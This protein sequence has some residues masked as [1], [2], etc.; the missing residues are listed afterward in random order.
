MTSA[1]I[2]KST[3]PNGIRV[4]TM[5]MP[6]LYSVSMGIWVDAGARDETTDERG[7]SHFIEHMIFKG[8]RRRSA[9]QIAKEFDTIGGATNA[10]TSMEN[11]CYY[12]KVMNGQ[13]P[14]MVDILSD[15][16]IN[17]VFDQQE[18][19]RE[20]PVIFQEISMLEDSPDEL[21]HHLAGQ[22]FWGDHP[23]GH[24]VIGT[25]ENLM[26]FDSNKLK[27]FFHKLYQ[28]ERIIISA[29]GMIDHS[30]FVDLL[31]PVFEMLTSTGELPQRE[32]PTSR[33]QIQVH[34]RD[35]EQ[36]HLCL[37][38]RGVATS[39]P[40][41]Y[42][43]SLLNTIL[44][45]NMSSRL[46]QEIREKYGLAYS[47]YSFVNSFEDA[48][49]FGIYAAVAPDHAVETVERILAAIRKLKEGPVS[50][51]ELKSAKDY[52]KGALL[53]SAESNDNQ[54]IRLAQQEIHFGR[55]VSMEEILSRIDGVSA[56][57]LLALS[58]R[59]FGDDQVALTT[60]GPI[61]DKSLFSGLMKP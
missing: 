52:T 59:L 57:D 3:L 1:S 27:Q 6:H 8:T 49:M 4:L 7:L 21:V 24:P 35:Q 22:N 14:T 43:I 2:Q 18:M 40:D 61:A 29:A 51:D 41:R 25:R 30:V 53:L 19:E 15:I 37:G 44:G 9:Y 48:G 39:N 38:S 58:G 31:H 16:F 12:A 55:H 23:L 34:S 5:P 13:L 54:M 28:P 50:A 46:F 32:K 33:F 47:I 17:S 11:T 42:A 60:L 26:R 10:F 20:R 36:V 56:Q 45:G